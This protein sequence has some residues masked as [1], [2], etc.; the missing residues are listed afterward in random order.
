MT[1]EKEMGEPENHK[2]KILVVDDSETALFIETMILRT[3]PYRLVTAGDGEEAVGKAVSERPDLILMD[4]VMPKMDGFAAC[5]LLRARP[6]TREIP[7]IVVTTRGE[8]ENV[9]TGFASGCTDYVTKP[10]NSVEL[11]EK[12]K[13]YI[14][15]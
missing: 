10:I 13:N 6:E 14:G 2:K 15:A 11:L 4:V 9:E 12:V 5:R 8:A 3:G 7:I 1:E